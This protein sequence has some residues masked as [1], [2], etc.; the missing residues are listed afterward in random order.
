MHIA[1]VIASIGIAYALGTFPSAL[2]IARRKGVDI[3]THGSGNPGASN[4]TRVLG[5]KHGVLVYG[6]DAGKGALGAAIGLVVA[7]RAAGFWCAAVAVLGHVFPV[8]RKFKG[9]K[10]VATASGAMLVMQPFV[11]VFVLALFLTVG[12]TTKKASLGSL[13]ATIGLP[14]FMIAAGEPAWEIMAVVGVGLL[15]VIRHIPNLKRLSSGHE[16]SLPTK[17]T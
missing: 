12:K 6:L 3:T 10:G 15:I 4:T 14:A 9:G 16:H 1:F 8:T 5:W 11:S 13:S 7:G 17:A 2:V